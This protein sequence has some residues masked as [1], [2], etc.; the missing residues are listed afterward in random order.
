MPGALGDDDF[1]RAPAAKDLGG[2]A[3]D[4]RMSV[5]LGRVAI[6][7]DEV[8]L[9]ED[10]P[11][12]CPRGA[13]AQLDRRPAPMIDS[14][15]AWYDAA[16]AMKTWARSDRSFQSRTRAAA[17]AEGRQPPHPGQEIASIH[18]ACL[19]SLYRNR[20]HDLA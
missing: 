16:L 14:R 13:E 17:H 19:M 6:R 3:H 4:Q 18:A 1:A 8:G 15:S 2:R 5:D 20:D 9:Q 11:S 7:L 12:F 10:R